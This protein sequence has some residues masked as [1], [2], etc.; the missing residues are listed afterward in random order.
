MVEYQFAKKH[1]CWVVEIGGYFTDYKTL[2]VNC[3]IV[4]KEHFRRVT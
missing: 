3:F 4:K 2:I 1:M